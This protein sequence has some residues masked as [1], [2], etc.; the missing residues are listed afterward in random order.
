[1]PSVRKMTA[2]EIARVEAKKAAAAKSFAAAY[3]EIVGELQP[4]DEIELELDLDEPS[5][6][7]MNMLQD[8]AG[9]RSPPLRL[10]FAAINDPLLLR[11]VA[12][13]LNPPPRSV[14]VGD[15]SLPDLLEFD[16][17]QPRFS[18]PMHRPSTNANR[19]QRPDR[20]DSPLRPERPAPRR[21]RNPSIGPNEPRG[22]RNA[23]QGS[24]DQRRN[25]QQDRAQWSSGPASGPPP[26][27]SRRR[28]R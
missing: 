21:A 4:G 24:P 27:R 1:M 20:S 14:V 2:E 25:K 6:A 9:R 11:F 26:P 5:L 8:A 23:P 19:K 13:L 22:S 10:E 17:P 12:Q 15:G 3:D 28:P 7:A 18:G 16:E